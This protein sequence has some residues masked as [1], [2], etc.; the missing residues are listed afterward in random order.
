M[1]TDFIKE[2]LSE[3]HQD[4]KTSNLFNNHIDI[5]ENEFFFDI[6]ENINN[7][8]VKINERIL[9]LYDTQ[10]FKSIIDNNYLIDN[11]EKSDICEIIISHFLFLIQN[12]DL[13]FVEFHLSLIKFKNN[14]QNI[15]FTFFDK[16]CVLMNFFI[17]DIFNLIKYGYDINKY[18]INK[19]FNSN[20]QLTF[21]SFFIVKTIDTLNL[22]EV[23]D[24]KEFI[25]II[26]ILNYIFQKLLN[27]NVYL[28]KL[29]CFP[30]N[31]ISS[32]TC[33]LLIKIIELGNDSHINYYIS[34]YTL[35]QLND[36]NF[37]FD[38]KN[39]FKKFKIF[40]LLCSMVNDILYKEFS[41]ECY[42]CNIFNKKIMK[43]RDIIFH[44][45]FP[46]NVRD[47]YVNEHKNIF[48]FI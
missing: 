22:Y 26:N 48:R 10:Y 37:K 38:N 25:Y 35:L 24:D 32:Y 39:T 18:C 45:K 44:Q 27:F 20:T 41:E 3:V 46:K 36:I 34:N 16:T 23:T 40:F 7:N 21:I 1:D 31:L 30:D 47:I 2:V 5:V 19:T 11:N 15:D 4:D 28:Q 33:Y 13:R 6:F 8:N 17:N 9:F 43:V 12:K 14:N 29:N 42:I